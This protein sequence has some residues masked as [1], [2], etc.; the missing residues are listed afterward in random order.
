[1]SRY[2]TDAWASR[3]RR[4]LLGR[5]RSHRAGR[6]SVDAVDRA[7]V[8]PQR[9]RRVVLDSGPSDP[10][11]RC[12]RTRHARRS[13]GRGSVRRLRRDRGSDRPAPGRNARDFGARHFRSRVHARSRRRS[14]AADW[15]KKTEERFQKAF[16]AM[17]TCKPGS[18]SRTGS[19]RRSF[20]VSAPALWQ[21][22]AI[23]PSR[24]RER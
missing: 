17:R 18:A 20:W 9:G 1:M 10:R 6:H 8:R 5:R 11:A 19:A 3:M 4:Q 14:D 7:R 12:A 13:V 22:C 21:P 24:A 15:A 16:D 2:L 23:W